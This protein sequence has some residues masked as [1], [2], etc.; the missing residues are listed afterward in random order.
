MLL[1]MH[2]HTSVADPHVEQLVGTEELLPAIVP[3]YLQ[4]DSALY[5]TSM[6]Q[7]AP[8]ADELNRAPP[9]SHRATVDQKRTTMDGLYRVH[10]RETAID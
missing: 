3:A 10:S 5:A 7:S 9:R 8:D 2:K 1:Y 4:H 6:S